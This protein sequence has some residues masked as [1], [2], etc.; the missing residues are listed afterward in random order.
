MMTDKICPICKRE[1]E[2]TRHV[3]VE[4]FYAVNEVVPNI[5]EVQ[6]FNEVD[7]NDSIWGIT[8]RYKNGTRDEHSCVKTGP[9]STR[10]DT[11]QVPCGDIRLVEMSMFSQ[12]CC[13]SCRADFLEMFGKWC[14]GEFV[15]KEGEGDIP[16]RVLGATKMLTEEQWKERV[17]KKGCG[18][19]KVR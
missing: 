4:C 2:D 13:K 10:I 16:V 17:L 6:I 9:N 7:E 18:N 11:K 15:T 14:K 8:R 12:T 3:A 19:E 1:M 5:E